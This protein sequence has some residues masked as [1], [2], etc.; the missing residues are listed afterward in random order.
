MDSAAPKQDLFELF[1][2]AV[3]ENDIRTLTDTFLQLSVRKDSMGPETRARFEKLRPVYLSKVSAAV[4][5]TGN[6]P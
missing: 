2:K 4:H 5:G 1:E 6:D 3:V